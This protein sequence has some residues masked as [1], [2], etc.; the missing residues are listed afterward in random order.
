MDYYL[1]HN[2]DLYGDHP[3]GPYN[4]VKVRGLNV[5]YPN[6]KMITGDQLKVM[7]DYPRDVEN[8]K[9]PIDEIPDR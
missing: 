5:A 1:I 9:I 7:W 4:A 6:C 2:N 3:R 8:N